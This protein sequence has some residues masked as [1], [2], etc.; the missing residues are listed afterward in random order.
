MLKILF[1]ATIA[2]SVADDHFAAVELGYPCVE[3]NRINQKNGGF[4]ADT[5]KNYKQATY[6]VFG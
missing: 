6:G 3:D 5:L 4:S 1:Y 2:L